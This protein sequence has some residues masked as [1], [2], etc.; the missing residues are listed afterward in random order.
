MEAPDAS[1]QHPSSA[2]T[3]KKAK[4]KKDKI[5]P[6]ETSKLLAAR[7]SEL[8]QNAAGEKD[9]EAEID[10]E[11]KKATRDLNQLLN[12]MES[13]MSRL[14]TVQKKYAELLADM[15]R[16]DRDYAKSKKKADQLQKEQERSK[17][18]ASK[19]NAVR[20]KLEK[21][22]RELTKET[23]KLKACIT[24]TILL[25]SSNKMIQEDN[26]K[27]E[28]TE[29]KAHGFVNEQLDTLLY[30]VQELMASKS[31]SQAENLY[32]ELDDLYVTCHDLLSK[33][34]QSRFRIRLK[35]VVDQNEL[36]EQHFKSILRHK[37]A[38]FQLMTMRYDDQ[39]RKAEEQSTKC[40]QLSNQ[41]STFSFT[42]AELRN[43]LNIY[44][45]KF[46]QVE[47]TLNNSNDLFL[48]FRKEM[49]EMSKKTKRLEKEN[50]NL[51]RKHESTSR[52]VLAMAEERTKDKQEIAK[53][54]KKETHM[55]RIIESMREQGRGEP[56]GLEQEL[57]EEGTE[58]E[59]DEEYDEEEDEVS[60]ED[61]PEELPKPFIGPVPPP[62]LVETTAN[63]TRAQVNGVSH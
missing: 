49:E 35:A 47:D 51:T 52:N 38:E 32:T 20:D 63:G 5:K 58:S 44:V 40:R 27:L 28:E 29:K 24:F 3:G 39:R 34:H 54:Q 60:E 22:C 19:N 61:V 37:D 50:L 30:D 43:Q 55:R 9:Q 41:V 10:R 59:Y 7:I 4:T 8:E 13:P 2:S 23:R 1:V 11:V 33:A 12:N 31:S 36:R 15:K 53:L 62:S 25:L 18:E 45:D 16:L 26:K 46:K 17:S 14:E 21:L 6:D 48:S 56:Q 42:E 57:D